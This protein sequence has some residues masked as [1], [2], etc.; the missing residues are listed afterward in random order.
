LPILTPPAHRFSIPPTLTTVASWTD[1]GRPAIASD[2]S[3]PY[4]REFLAR[5]SMRNL[6]PTLSIEQS[7]A[8]LTFVDPQLLGQVLERGQHNRVVAAQQG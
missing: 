8:A 7:P 1:C 4:F 3:L 6:K 2:E 5:E